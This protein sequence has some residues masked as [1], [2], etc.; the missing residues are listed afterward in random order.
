MPV[1]ELILYELRITLNLMQ[2]L[3]SYIF[4]Y[5]EIACVT[6]VTLNL[7]VA[8]YEAPQKRIIVIKEMIT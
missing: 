4:L 5:V 7:T 8:P 2:I 3:R 6:N 1:L